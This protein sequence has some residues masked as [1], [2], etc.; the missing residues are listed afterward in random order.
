MTER[1]VVGLE[2]EVLPLE[3]KRGEE[4]VDG[5]SGDF[6]GVLSPSDFAVGGRRH[7]STVLSRVLCTQC[8]YF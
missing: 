8:T 3:G 6:T 1:E 7:I 4:W 2:E 5:G